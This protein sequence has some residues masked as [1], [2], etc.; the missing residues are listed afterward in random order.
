MSEAIEYILARG[1]EIYLKNNYENYRDR[2][3]DLQQ[4]INFVANYVD[5]DQLLADV[6]LSESF[7]GEHEHD[8]KVMVLSTIHQ[9]K[10][11]EWP[12]VFIVGLCDGHFPHQ[13]C[14]EKPKELEEERRLFYVAVTRA[15]NELFLLY[16]IRSFSYKFGEVFSKPS[17]FIRELDKT[18]Y[19]VERHNKF[20]YDSDNNEDV[21][22]VH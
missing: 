11:L 17:M 20:D 4:L 5:L 18:R 1:Y 21:I 19:S 2:L 9:A 13:K 3:D 12:V 15:Q 7:A 6:T 22:Y 10:G 14:L 8:R 16:P